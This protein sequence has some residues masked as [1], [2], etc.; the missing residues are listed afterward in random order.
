MKSS[1]GIGYFTRVASNC[2]WKLVPIT[3]HRT[4]AVRSIDGQD[5]SY[6]QCKDCQRNSQY[7]I[8]EL[9]R[10]TP[11]GRLS[12]YDLVWGWCGVCDIGRP[13]E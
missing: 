9:S 11:S 3:M 8:I 2:D 12:E 7:I 4:I 13:P 5:T 10:F 6:S 1:T